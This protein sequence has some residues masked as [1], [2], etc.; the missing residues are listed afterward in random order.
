MEGEEKAQWDLHMR[1]LKSLTGFANGLDCLQ[2]RK[3]HAVRS[4]GSQCLYYTQRLSRDYVDT[5]HCI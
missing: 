2:T 3:V 1:F 5:N 4:L